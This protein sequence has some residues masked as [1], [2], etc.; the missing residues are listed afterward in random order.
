VQHF[1]AGICV[2]FFIGIPVFWFFLR[3]KQLEIH[4]INNKYN[5]QLEE[6]GKLTGQLAHEIKN[7]LST[8]KVN[9]KLIGE[10]LEPLKKE[11]KGEDKNRIISG[12]FRKIGVIE[13]EADRLEEILNGF[14]R[15]TAKTEL[16]LSRIDINELM[17]DMVDF[18]SPKAQSC[19]VTIRQGIWKEP[20]FCKLDIDT[21]KQ[22]IL[23]LFINSQQAMPDGGELIIRTSRDKN[24]ALVEVSDTGIGIA[25][26]KLAGIF[27]AYYTSR[28]EGMGLGLVTAKKIIEAH[29]GLISVESEPGK[30]TSFTIRLPIDNQ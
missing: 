18:F 28:R 30:G 7:P 3:K 26:N 14:L 4:R 2:V 24:E 21:F 29:K 8:I 23:N 19:S 16:N 11:E 1:L 27:D 20:L 22:V 17:S 10:D 6:S 13:K 5:K 15:Y 25:P 12:A 9:L